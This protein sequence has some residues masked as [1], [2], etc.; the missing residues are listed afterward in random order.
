MKKTILFVSIILLFIA[1]CTFDKYEVPRI[2]TSA[3]S[4]CDTIVHYATTIA[5]LILST[6]ATSGCHDGTQSNLAVYHVLQ[7]HSAAVVDRIN[8]RN[9]AL[10]PSAGAPLSAADISKI[11]CWVNQG[12]QQN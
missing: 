2:S 7:V 3:S 4:S 12:A 9:G 11:T 8:G 6:C 1:S 10:M 5:P